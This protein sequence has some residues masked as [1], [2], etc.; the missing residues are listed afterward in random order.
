[1]YCQYFPN[2]QILAKNYLKEHSD[3]FFPFGYTFVEFSSIVLWS[4]SSK[5]QHCK[6]I[7]IR[8]GLAEGFLRVETSENF[9]NFLSFPLFAS[10]L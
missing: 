10:F 7:S 6:Q 3:S 9:H 2:Q 1:M 4:L 8:R 5:Q